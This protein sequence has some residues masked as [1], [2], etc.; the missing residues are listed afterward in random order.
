MNEK[1]A[2]TPEEKGLYFHRLIET[3]KHAYAYRFHLG[4]ESFVN[5]SEVCFVLI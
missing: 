5:L 4:D 2:S 3:F 1:V